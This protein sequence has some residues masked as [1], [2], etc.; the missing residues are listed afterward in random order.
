MVSLPNNFINILPS[1]GN[2][3]VLSAIKDCRNLYNEAEIL[4]IAEKIRDAGSFH[5]DRSTIDEFLNIVSEEG[6][7]FFPIYNS[8]TGSGGFSHLNSI[9]NT[10]D[11]KVFG[12]VSRSLDTAKKFKKASLEITKDVNKAQNMLLISKMMGYPDCCS[13][14]FLEYPNFD[15]V[16]EIFQNSPEMN[17]KLY[18]HL[19]YFG[20]RVVP[21]FP[22]SFGC[23]ESSKFSDSW[24]DLLTKI[25]EKI[26]KDLINLLSPPSEWSLCNGQVEV[27]HEK[28]RGYA[29]SYYSPDL[30]KVKF[31]NAIC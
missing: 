6:L 3:D 15:P 16:L 8:S 19:R 18:I 23:K 9:S 24:L 26:T 17:P 10:K 1:Y 28:F 13:K 22:C 12:V 25:D 14:K 11:S 31:L 27:I 2:S 30:L 5:V 7:I 29:T 4:S 20:L 21:W